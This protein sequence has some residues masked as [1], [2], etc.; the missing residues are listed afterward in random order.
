MKEF[1]VFRKIATEFR[2]VPDNEVL[3][4]IELTSPFLSKR[5]FGKLYEQALVYMTAH[6]MKLAGLGNNSYGTVGDT[7]RVA[8]FNEGDTSISYSTN[9]AT[10][11]MSD[12]E[13]ALTQYGL[14]YLTIRRMKVF[15]VRTT[16]G[17]HGISG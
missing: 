4:W 9:Q 16:G 5:V 1:K 8:S 14:S 13:L 7:L 17:V 11:L 2:A 6:R 12:G 15:P 3:E 10:N